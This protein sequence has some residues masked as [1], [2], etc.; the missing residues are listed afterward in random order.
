[1]HIDKQEENVWHKNLPAGDLIHSVINY[2]QVPYYFIFHDC[3]VN[4]QKLI[5]SAVKLMG[6]WIKVVTSGSPYLI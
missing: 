3:T 6:H 2:L 4:V 5:V 1:M